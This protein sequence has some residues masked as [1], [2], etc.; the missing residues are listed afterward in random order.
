MWL[1]QTRLRYCQ[2]LAQRL[3]EES[4]KIAIDKVHSGV[5]QDFNVFEVL[6]LQSAR[7][8]NHL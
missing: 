1:M 7:E 2:A 3:Q 4:S 8:S 5:L 6:G